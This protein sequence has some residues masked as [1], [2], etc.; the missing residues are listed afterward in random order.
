MNTRHKLAR[1]PQN[2][3]TLAL[4][5]NSTHQYKN[6]GFINR[7]NEF[8]SPLFSHYC[9]LSRPQ[10]LFFD[11]LHKNTW[12]EGVTPVAIGPSRIGR[13]KAVRQEKRVWGVFVFWGACMSDMNARPTKEEERSLP[14]AARRATIRRARKNRAAPVGMTKR[15]GGITDFGSICFWGELYVGAPDRGGTGTA[16]APINGRGPGRRRD[17]SAS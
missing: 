13:G 16:P 10:P 5:T 15:E 1:T 6:K 12:G 4:C 8:L 9:A 14:S 11:T 3:S 7:N 17:A 2:S